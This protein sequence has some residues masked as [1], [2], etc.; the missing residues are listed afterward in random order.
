[1]AVTKD[2]IR[3]DECGVRRIGQTRVSLDSVVIAYRNGSSA[4]AIQESYPA[5]NLEEVYGAITYFLA[6]MPEV[7]AYLEDQ[8]KVAEAVRARSEAER[9]P[10]V[11]RLRKLM[12][13]REASRESARRGA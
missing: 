12:R 10:V 1:M 9:P 2:Y 5:L 11:D 8:R 7:D 4:E 3:V 6:N 13:E